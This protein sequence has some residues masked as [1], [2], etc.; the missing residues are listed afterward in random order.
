MITPLR[1]S[2]SMHAFSSSFFR[3]IQEESLLNEFDLFSSSDFSDGV[4]NFHFSNIWI[5]H[6]EITTAFAFIGW[7]GYTFY[8]NKSMRKLDD[9]TQYKDLQKRIRLF[10][11]IFLTIFWRNIDNAI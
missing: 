10:I 1:T 3:Q 7:F 5:Q 9:L 6:W 11:L 2:L 4:R 8:A